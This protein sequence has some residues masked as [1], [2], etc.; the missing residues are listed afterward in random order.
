[1]ARCFLRR[2]DRRA[3]LLRNLGF[4]VRAAQ[5]ADLRRNLTG[6]WDDLDYLNY[7]W[8]NFFY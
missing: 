6:P 2:A 1:L 3:D 7:R 5:R 8:L 4:L